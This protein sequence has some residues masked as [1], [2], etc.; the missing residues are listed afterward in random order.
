MG[1]FVVAALPFPENIPPAILHNIFVAGAQLSFKLGENDLEASKLY[2]DYKYT[3]VDDYLNLCV[4][5]P[6]KPKLAAFA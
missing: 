3:T 2:P 1:C 5:D 6:P 4:I